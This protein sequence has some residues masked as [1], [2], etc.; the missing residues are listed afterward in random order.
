MFTETLPDRT[1]NAGPVAIQMNDDWRDFLDFA[2]DCIRSAE[3]AEKVFHEHAVNNTP[4]AINRNRIASIDS[5]IALLEK[6]KEE[7]CR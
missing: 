4:R 3:N 2:G 6:A 1:S 7:L 5:A